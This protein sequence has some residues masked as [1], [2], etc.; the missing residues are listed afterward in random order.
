MQ[1]D[2]PALGFAMLY[3]ADLDGALT[4]LTEKLG[5]I[6]VPEQ[7][8]A[9]FHFLVGGEGGIPFGIGQASATSPQ[10]GTIELAFKTANVDDLHAAYAE[11]DVNPP[12][13]EA[14]PFGRSF[15]LMPFD[16]FAFE[17]WT[18]PIIE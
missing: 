10:P 13:I 14:K 17:F 15:T 3:V 7:S 12:A 5:F 1:H 4:Y 8:D 11:K 2:T 16:G 18:D 6:R 9:S